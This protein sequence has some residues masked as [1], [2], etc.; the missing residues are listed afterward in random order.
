MYASNTAKMVDERCFRNELPKQLIAETSQHFPDTN[1]FGPV[2]RLCCCKIDKIYTG[3]N[4]KKGRY[5]SKC[6]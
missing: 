2:E 4:D 1:F 6:P 5:K 3:G